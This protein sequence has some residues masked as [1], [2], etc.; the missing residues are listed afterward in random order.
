MSLFQSEKEAYAFA[1]WIH[2]EALRRGYTEEEAQTRISSLTIQINQER[3][4]DNTTR[5][6]Q[7][8]RKTHETLH[9]P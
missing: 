7:A 1:D 3:L 2:A 9:N 6:L 8:F 4:A 5:L